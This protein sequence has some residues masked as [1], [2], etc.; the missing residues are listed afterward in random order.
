M[1]SVGDIYARIKAFRAT[2][3][4]GNHTLYFAKVDVRS[5]FDTIPQ[6]AVIDLMKRIP[7]HSR[8]Q[9]AKHVE[10]R[11]AE[12][13][14]GHGRD[15]KPI[16]RWNSLAKAAG[17]T[18]PFLQLVEEQLGT[19]RTG[20]VFIDSIVQKSFDTE[21]L[22]SLLVSH[23]RQNMVKIGKKYY[24]QKQGIPQGSVLS[25]TL[26]NY[27]YADLEMRH[28]SFLQ[29]EDCLLLRLIDDFLLITRTKSKAVR[30]VRTMHAGLPD[31]GVAV[32]EGK[33]L[34]NF[35]MSTGSSLVP[36]LQHTAQFP[37]CGTLIDCGTLDVSKDRESP[38]DPGTNATRMGSCLEG[39][40]L[41]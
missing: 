36:R 24:R 25:S 1:F 4:S 22:M 15:H 28:L 39:H 31:Y 27:F 30:F 38:K 20:T 41:T 14:P 16:S 34:V 23:V 35:E 32:S 10:I 12:S 3:A 2:L 9:I 13:A 29:G 7:G 11:A 37:Y 5:A 6:R 26:C 8:Y 40:Y 33:S 18:A 17:D 21:A 19:K